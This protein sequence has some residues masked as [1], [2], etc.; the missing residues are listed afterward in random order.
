MRFAVS[1]S[2]G[3]RLKEVARCC[4]R[5]RRR[6]LSSG[7]ETVMRDDLGRL[8]KVRLALSCQRWR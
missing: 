2:I 3:V 1:Y 6:W 8:I 4:P 7:S 5:A